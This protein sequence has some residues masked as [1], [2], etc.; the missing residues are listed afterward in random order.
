MYIGLYVKYSLFSDVNETWIFSTFSKNIEIPNFVKL[1]SP[2]T[3]VSNHVTPRNNPEDGRIQFNR[4][5]SLR[6]RSSNNNNAT[7]TTT[8]TTTPLPPPPTTTTQHLPSP[9]SAHS[10]NPSGWHSLPT[11]P[12][13]PFCMYS[14][15]APSNNNPAAVC[16]AQGRA[17][18]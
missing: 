14:L 13:P 4:G 18:V 16:L 1:R 17:T 5:R 12:A 9:Q 11:N 7:T 8:T 10:S 15:H 2:E 6:L 3:S